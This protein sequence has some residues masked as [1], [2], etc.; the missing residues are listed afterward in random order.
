MHGA[1]I[2][3][4]ERRLKRIM[5]NAGTEI[6]GLLSLLLSF[7]KGLTKNRSACL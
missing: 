4:F 6:A 7:S 3:S 2:G 5:T 1:M